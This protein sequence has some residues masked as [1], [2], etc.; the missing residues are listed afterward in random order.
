MPTLEELRIIVDGA[1]LAASY[2]PAG[3]TAL[4]ALQSAGE[5]T[6]GDSL[7][8]A[9]LHDVLP[10]SGV[11]VLTFDRRGEGESTGDASRGRFRLQSDDALALLDAISVKRAGLWGYSQ[12]AWIAPLAAAVSERVSFLVLVASTG[13]TPSE[14]MMY[15]T[16]TQLRLGGFGEDVVDRALDLRRRFDAWTRGDRREEEQ[17]LRDDLLTA[18]DEPW[19]P[20]LFLPPGLPDEEGC[21]LWLEEMDFDP[22]PIFAQ[23]HVPVLAFY[24]ARD[25]WTPVKP[26]VEAWRLARGDVTIVV[27][28]DAEHDLTLP[29]GSLAREYEPTLVEWLDRQ[30]DNATVE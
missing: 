10:A 20:L 11:G 6:R 7:L 5:G 8:Y 26:S 13:V 4:I 3:E 25:S 27:V 2:S 1:T 18:L 15:A 17:R 16:E 24:G 9:H 28:P 12:G 21:R 19:F 29:D 22:R 14:Q 30:S 23:V